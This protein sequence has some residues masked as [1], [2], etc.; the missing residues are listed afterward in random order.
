MDKEPAIVVSELHKEFVLP[1]HKHTSL[2]QLF[3]NIAKGGRNKKVMQKAL[4]NVNFEVKKGEFFGIVGRNGSGKSTLL[5]ILAGVYAPTK[6]GVIVNGKLTPFIELGVGFNPE[7]SGRDNVFLN[8]ALLGFSHKEMAVMYQDIVDF[9]EI[10]KFMDQKLKNYSS[11]MQVRLAFSIAI[12]AK[13]DILLI[14]E[15]L[16]VGDTNFQK[17]CFEVFE[18]LKREGRTI[19]F[20]THSM[21]HVRDFCNRVAVINKGTVAFIGDIEEGIDIY[22][23][24]N[25]EDENVRSEIENKERENSK[26]L[27]TGKATITKYEIFN[28]DNKESVELVTDKEFIVRLVITANE[29]VKN[30][31]TG[32]MFRK[33]PQVNLYGLNSYTDGHPIK[34]IKK[35]ET[36][37]VIF[38][39]K[40]PLNPGVYFVSFEV[41]TMM[42]TGYEDIDYLVNILK[43]NVTGPELYWAVV[44]STPTISIRDLK[45]PDE[46]KRIIEPRKKEKS[47]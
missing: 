47:S 34:E 24:L 26:R 25:A 16:A 9:A 6:G 45:D 5:K 13:S 32:V 1:Q 22:N 46:K 10:E 12:R 3:V 42:S 29:T 20:V 36:V 44:S 37:E 2:K 15:V 31:S 18:E 11:G 30:C 40:L 8:G 35:G 43:I 4:S 7:L 39:A 28:H 19:V 38:K 33:D 41:A 14:D 27:G 21:G 23:K 17:K